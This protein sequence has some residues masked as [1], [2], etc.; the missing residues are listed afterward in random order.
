[1]GDSILDNQAYIRG[2]P[3]VAAQVGTLL[4]AGSRC[5]LA[6]IDGSVVADVPGQL[7]RAPEDAT[8]LVISAGGND[9]LRQEGLLH[10]EARSVAEGLARLS[11]MAGAFRNRY[12]AM[13][14][15]VARRRLP[16]AVC[17]I[18][19]P[20]FPDPARQALALTGLALFN[21]AILR[22]AF[23]RRLTVIDLRL[24][25]T[26]PEDFANPI[27]PSSLGG[28]KIAAAIA[29]FATGQGGVVLTGH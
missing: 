15:A 24:I 26:A 17:T 25:C 27:E 9:A 2:N 1:M 4:P 5:T 18:Y 3:D 14:D 16:T 13:L 19:D 12:G 7:A 6:A 20:R 28:A 22:E 10:T 21:D 29:S 23:G 8:H 11:G